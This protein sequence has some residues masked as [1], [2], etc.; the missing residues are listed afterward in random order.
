MSDY[1]VGKGRPPKEHQFP[2]NQSGNLRGRPTKSGAIDVMAIL[3]EPVAISQ[4]GKTRKM[5]PSE[6]ILLRMVK[7]AIKDENLRSILYLLERFDRYGLL[8][9]LPSAVDCILRLPGTM[10]WRMAWDMAKRFGAPPWN[11]KQKAIGREHYITTRT[12]EERAVDE[13]MG[14]PDL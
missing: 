11:D 5:S 14:Y 2:P 8:A 13:A 7:R 9:P 3:D 6:V 1:R 4:D 12:E 10:P